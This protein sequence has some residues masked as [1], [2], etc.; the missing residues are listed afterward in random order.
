MAALD[1]A[2]ISPT[3]LFNNHFDS[4]FFN[5]NN[6]FV[7]LFLSIQLL[8]QIDNNYRNVFS[9]HIVTVS[10]DGLRFPITLRIPSGAKQRFFVLKKKNSC[11]ISFDNNLFII[12]S[13]IPVG[14][15]YNKVSG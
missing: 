3:S 5:D 10:L 1:E 14:G 12:R 4:I 11:L 8:R 9:I 6:L 2:H 7:S 13:L 15:I